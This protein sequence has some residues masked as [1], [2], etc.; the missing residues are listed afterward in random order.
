MVKLLNKE[1]RKKI[2]E[3]K[4]KLKK[5]KE[6]FLKEKLEFEHNFYRL[7]FEFGLYNKFNKTYMLNITDKTNYGYLATLHLEPGVYFSA[8]EKYI[9][10]LQESLGCI[11]IMKTVQ[12]KKYAHLKIVTQPLDEETPYENPKVKPWEMYLG[13]DFSLNVIKINCNDRCMFLIGGATG[14]G[15]TRLLYMI[16]LSWII[17]C[18]P[19]EVELFLADVAKDGFSGIMYAKHVKYYARELDTLLNMLKYIHIKLEKRRNVIGKLREQGI[20]TNIIEY[21]RTQKSKMSYC[22][23][24]IDEFSFL[25][26]EKSDSKEEKSIKEEII[27]LVKQISKVGRE[28]GIFLIVG[29]QKTVR[30]EI[31]SIIKNMSSVRIS[32]RAND[33]ISSEVIMGDHTAVGL[34]DRYAV[35]SFSGESGNK[36]YLFSP[37][38]TTS[39]LNN[40]LQQY[41]D[42][43]RKKL[44]LGKEIKIYN[45]QKEQQPPSKVSQIKQNVIKTPQYSGIKNKEDDF[46]DY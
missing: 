40:M 4:Q 39:M 10:A 28:M 3:E 30:D 41:V 21:N 12:F 18:K 1:E 27:S 22:Y 44:D 16:C 36:D 11:W 25:V 24:I 2:I 13:L 23:V 19:N 33:A 32:F 8:L 37:L 42:K 35:Y 14:A 31:P 34:L 7:M 46:V 26:P 29:V 20:A 45:E 5:E 17:N 38:L 15:K 43:T 6:D 9:G